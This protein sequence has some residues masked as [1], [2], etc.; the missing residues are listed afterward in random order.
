M[1]IDPKTMI[2]ALRPAIKRLRYPVEIMLVCVRWNIADPLSLRH[3]EEMMAER[4]VLVDH[5]TIHRWANRHWQLKGR[6]RR[7]GAVSV[8]GKVP[9]RPLIGAR[10]FLSLGAIAFILSGCGGGDGSGGPVGANFSGADFNVD[11]TQSSPPDFTFAYLQGA[12]L[13]GTNLTSTS[14]SG[15]FVD[16]SA[17]HTAF[18]GGEAPNASVCVQAVYG[19][20]Y[21][22]VPTN[23]PTMTC[24]DGNTYPTSGCGLTQAS[25]TRWASSTP[26]GQAT[27]S[28][29]YQFPPTYGVADQSKACNNGPYNLDCRNRQG[30]RGSW[31]T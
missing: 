18:K 30:R 20:S 16:F 5:S 24:P 3:L 11:P 4:G 28:G 14:L 12:I 2:A 17:L 21:T 15:A 23:I 27:P 19:P 29:F 6:S 1:R 9:S 26:I 8:R 10:F 13:A 25:S 31:R 7:Q 22:T